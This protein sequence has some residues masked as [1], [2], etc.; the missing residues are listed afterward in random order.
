MFFLFCFF[1]GDPNKRQTGRSRCLQGEANTQIQGGINPP[2]PSALPSRPTTAS[3]MV[4]RQPHVRSPNA[5]VNT[6]IKF[7]LNQQS[8]LNK[9]QAGGF[10]C[11]FFNADYWEPQQWLLKNL[12]GDQSSGDMLHK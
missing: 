9:P 12:Y 1:Q 4:H 2:Q 3:V 7:V 6:I 10:T 8:T 11:I 5:N